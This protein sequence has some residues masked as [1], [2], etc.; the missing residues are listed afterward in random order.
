MIFEEIPA[1][2]FSAYHENLTR[3]NL[4]TIAINA[5]RKKYQIK[6]IPVDH[7]EMPDESFWNDHKRMY[8]IIESISP[9]YNSLVDTNSVYTSMHGFRYLNSEQC[10]VLQEKLN[11]AIDLAVK[12][13]NDEKFN[14]LQ[15][16][17]KEIIAKRDDTMLKNIYEYTENNEFSTGVFLVGAA[18][19]LS[20]IRRIRDREATGD[21]RI[22]WNYQNYQEIF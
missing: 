9:E 14:K 19:R 6:N 11:M 21:G 1:S 4:E 7:D 18:H 2:L 13:L 8:E 17:W 22:S 12:H 10:T 20:I 3:Q 15:K 5:Y 16:F